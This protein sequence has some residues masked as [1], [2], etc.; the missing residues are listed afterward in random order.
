MFFS[1]KYHLIGA[2]ME[3]S[4]SKFKCTLPSRFLCSN[5]AKALDGEP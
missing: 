3:I 5:I 2:P 1:M 4:R